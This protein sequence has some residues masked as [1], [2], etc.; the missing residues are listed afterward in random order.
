MSEREATLVVSDVHL[1]A[2]PEAAERAFHRFLGSLPSLAGELLIDGD[3]F[4]FWFEY[5]SVILRR[6]FETLRRLADLVEAGVRIRMVRGNHDAWAADFL[7]DQ[8]GIELLRGEEVIDLHGRRTYVSHGDGL[9][10]GARLHRAF[11]R[12]ARSRPA[13]AA[14]RLVH[15]DLAV[16]F[17]RRVSRTTARAAAGGGEME[18]ARRLALHAERLLRRDPSLDLVVFGHAHHPELSEPEPGR[19]YLNPGDWIHH[20]SYGVVGPEGVALKRWRPG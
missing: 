11:R 10:G 8:I 19:H 7:R 20:R 18:R 4:D 9:G 12:L 2:V 1:G 13:V 16:R 3:L 5:R 17:A 6:H 14:F 15:P